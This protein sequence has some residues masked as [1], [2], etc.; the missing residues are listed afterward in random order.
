[1]SIVILGNNIMLKINYEILAVAVF[2]NNH[3]RIQNP[4]RYLR[5]SAFWKQLKASR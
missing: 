2:I 5:W 1:M 3:R 4:V